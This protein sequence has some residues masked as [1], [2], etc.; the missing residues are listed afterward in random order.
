MKY[1]NYKKYSN[2]FD[3]VYGLLDGD[4]YYAP[5]EKQDNRKHFIY[6][7]IYK[8][9]DALDFYIKEVQTLDINLANDIVNMFCK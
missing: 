8:D 2:L 5:S 6:M 7:M 3:K 9:L 1:S 4:R